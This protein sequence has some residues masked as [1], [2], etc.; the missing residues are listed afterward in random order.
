[1]NRLL[2]KIIGI[3]V[4][5]LSFILGWFLL[6]YNAF[7]NSSMLKEDR[8]VTFDIE[9]G[10]SLKSVAQ[11]LADQGFI[12]SPLYFEMMARLSG[13]GGQIQAGEFQ[14]VQGMSPQQ[15]LDSVTSGNVVQY[16]LTIVEGWTFKQLLQVI[17]D[18][19]QLKQTLTGLS[20]QDILAQ[21]KIDSQSAEGWFLPDTY[22]FPKNTSDVNFLRRAVKAMQTS[23]DNE[24]QKRKP[25][26][27]LNSPYEALILA[28]IV[29]KETALASE[30]RHIAG[31]FVRRL[32]IG[33]RLQTDPTVIY[34]MG[35]QYDG[36][37]RRDDLKR[38][39][40]YNT[41]TRDGLPPTPIALPS[42]DAVRA[43][44]DPAPGKTL[45]FVAKGDGSHYFSETLDEHNQAVM[46]Y[47]IKGVQ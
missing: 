3:T 32:Q 24:W 46:K 33:M 2:S 7:S 4:I 13:K 42:L 10:S 44:L 28:S 15:F 30:R 17:G 16:A 37:I 5:L 47:Q 34:G 18:V 43:V 40:P 1:M 19:P 6:G 41:Y 11:R 25:D 45:Y 38:D 27:P 26:L 36:D 12:D 23:L 21:L 35:D 22:H 8:F 20:E 9:P 29:E 14:I 31:V 39:T